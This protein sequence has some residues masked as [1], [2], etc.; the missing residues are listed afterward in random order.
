MVVCAN[1]SLAGIANVDDFSMYGRFAFGKGQSVFMNNAIVFGVSSFSLESQIRMYMS[2]LRELIVQIG[3]D[4]FRWNRVHIEVL[5]F[6][7][8][9]AFHGE[10]DNIAQSR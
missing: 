4:T 8:N 2:V 1:D 7:L 5:V 9:G 10:L 3:D 6:N